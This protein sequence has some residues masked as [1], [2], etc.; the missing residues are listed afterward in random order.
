[1]AIN[2]KQLEEAGIY[3]S[4]S[5]LSE[6]L[7]DLDQI[8][9]I[10]DDIRAK[11]R[12]QAKQG[13]WC[14]LGGL[15][16][17]VIGGIV[18]PPLLILSILVI[19]VGFIWWIM[20]LMKGARLLDHSGRLDVAKEC[21]AMLQPDASAK[22]KFLIRLALASNP[23]QISHEAWARRKNGKEELLEESWL[24]LSGSLMDGTAVADEVKDL[25][26][27][28]TYSNARGKSKS[29][30]RVTHLV[31]VRFNYPKELYGDARPAEQALRGQL[32]AG[33][34]AALRTVRASEKA[35]M[36]KALVTSDKAITETAGMLSLGGYRILNLARRMA[37]AQ[38]GE[39]K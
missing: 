28:R 32:K 12:Q 21:I 18:F 10:A 22:S 1:M 35:V 34:R 3:Q 39:S 26:R 37:S 23:T 25:T 15:I 33:P 8:L 19:I 30:T 11:K 24:S 5:P 31:N 27:R 4:E 2:Q 7:G 13:G 14:M 36:L 6:L 20:S 38:K 17:A 16:G 9:H 29:K